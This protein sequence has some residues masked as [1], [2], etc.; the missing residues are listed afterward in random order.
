[1]KTVGLVAPA[2]RAEAVNQA[3]RAASL[4]RA[5]GARV[6]TE[7]ELLPLLPECD[8]LDAGDRVDALVSLGGDGTLLRCAQYAAACDAPLLGINM[9]RLG[10][11][12][13]TEPEA[14]ED[15][16]RLLLSGKYQT[17]ERAML[18]VRMPDGEDR[19][20][21][22]DV[23]ITRGGYARLITMRVLV[24]GEEVGSYHADGL[25][26]ATP[27]GSTGYSLSAGGPIIS[28]RV[29][30]TVITPVCAHSLQHRPVVVPGSAVISV[31]LH[32]DDEMTASLQV[33][34]QSC[35]MLQNGGSVDIRRAAHSVRL[36]RL[37]RER[38]FEVVH[39]KLIEW[40][41]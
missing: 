40:S 23:V 10:F 20:A 19:V 32:S 15:A 22:N 11:L 13:E 2:S 39:H 33:D 6:V 18:A 1:M 36:V 14:L 34:G 5:L 8:A 26:V 21:L 25:I 27:T 30:C 12:A 9:G 4:L 38:F 31:Q 29:D 24:D 41:C 35:A 3:R 37:K 16:L 7:P 28:P 17:E